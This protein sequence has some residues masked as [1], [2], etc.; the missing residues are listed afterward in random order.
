MQRIEEELSLDEEEVAFVYLYGARLSLFR[1]LLQ[2]CVN[3][4]H[5]QVADST[6]SGFDL[7]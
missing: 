1:A 2:R 7:E 5:G 3:Y 4:I 6:L